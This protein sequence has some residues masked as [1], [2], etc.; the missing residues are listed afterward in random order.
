[1]VPLSLQTGSK[2][3]SDHT[4][5]CVRLR[6]RTN[7]VQFPTAYQI[8]TQQRLKTTALR[9]FRMEP[10]NHLRVYSSTNTPP[11]EDERREVSDAVAEGFQ[12]HQGRTH[13][14][15]RDWVI[16]D[17]IKLIEQARQ[18]CAKPLGGGAFLRTRKDLSRMLSE[19]DAFSF[20]VFS[21]FQLWR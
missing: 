8:L 18:T 10:R 15:R 19:P 12:A 17:T 11:K 2:N 21:D 7:A 16:S 20:D 9:N 4:V 14:R 5:I 6:K 3:A 1:M 13:L